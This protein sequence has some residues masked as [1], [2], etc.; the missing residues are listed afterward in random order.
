[1]KKY[2]KEL[3]KKLGGLTVVLV[4]YIEERQMFIAAT[5]FGKYC[6]TN[7]FITLPREK[8]DV[9]IFPTFYL[10]RVTPITKGERR[11]LVYWTGGEPF[12]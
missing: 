5:T 7:G 1:M 6:G 8:G 12:R 3:D 9:L 10:H 4:G 11:A 2:S